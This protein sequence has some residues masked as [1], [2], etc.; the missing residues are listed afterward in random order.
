VSVATTPFDAVGGVMIILLIETAWCR[1]H[2]FLYTAEG[3]QTAERLW[4]ETKAE[5]SGEI[6]IDEV[7]SGMDCEG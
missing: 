1:F 7:L 5:L 6:N 2:P 4:E 3:R